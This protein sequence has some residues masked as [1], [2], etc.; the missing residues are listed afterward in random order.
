MP[1]A[2]LTHQRF[3]RSPLLAACTLTCAAALALRADEGRPRV[4]DRQGVAPESALADSPPKNPPH[5]DA[6]AD[7]LAP[8]HA[9]SSVGDLLILEEA[10]KKDLYFL[11]NPFL[12]GRAPGTNGNRIAADF[13]Q[14][15]FESLGLDPVFTDEQ[16]KKS[17]RQPF[18]APASGRPGDSVVIQEQSLAIAGQSA[19]PGEDLAVLG[20]FSGDAALD[21]PVAFV[22]YS[23]EDGDD[24]YNSYPS[25]GEGNA[26]DLKGKI[27]LVMRFEPMDE[28]G[29]SKWETGGGWSPNAGLD[30]KLRA[31]RD[32]GAAGI[33][34]V[35]PPGADDPRA[36]RIEGTWLGVNASPW[37]IPV[38]M[39][40]TAFGD[41][42]VRAADA[43]GRSLLDLR[44]LADDKGGVIDLP[45]SN[46]QL[47][48]KA[49]R[50][51]LMTDNVGALLPGVG[52]LADQYVVVGGHYDHVGYGYFGSTAQDSRGTVHPGADDNASGTSGML[53]I[54]RMVAAT[55]KSLPPN[56]PRRGVIFLGFSAEESGLVGSRHY[57]QN[58][59][60]PIERHAIMINLD[61]IGRLRDS[62]LELA[63]HGTAQGLEGWLQPYVDNAGLAIASKKM[64]S[65]NSDH[66]SFINAGVPAIFFFTGIH[67]DY[68]KPS[69]TIDTINTAGAARAA[70]LA[71]RVAIDMALR[72]ERLVPADQLASGSS[73]ATGSASSGM[74]VRFGIMPGDYSDQTDGVLVGGTTAGMPAEKAGLKKGDRITKWNDQPVKNVEEWMSLLAKH[75]PGD[76]VKVTYLRDG[77]ELETQAELVAGGG[78]GRR[79]D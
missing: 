10:Y 6:D 70:D 69:D 59:P 45:K 17:Y 18:V 76:K 60:F 20:F 21:M 46:V 43:Q 27:A 9:P 39:V 49:L 33:I 37:E 42:L 13:I 22:G 64:G 66:A 77:A 41:R 65:P 1:Q 50:R 19:V 23:I 5:Q 62:K 79:R 12:E 3:S 34:L 47:R 31:A 24:G 14:H 35:N 26:P 11:A 71:G 54:A 40:S 38:V 57:T 78:G 7:L 32:H 67:E 4:D 61:M 30:T 28:N 58:P 72:T 52:E 8:R 25:V 2:R 68:H 73:P 74:R 63:G 15:A 44:R 16:G 29:Q 56:T 53:A 51:E 55:W 48:V 75:K 36:S